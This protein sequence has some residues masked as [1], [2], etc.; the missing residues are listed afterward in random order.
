MR[1][2]RRR[3]HLLPLKP[4]HL[5]V[6]LVLTGSFVVAMA[7]LAIL[8][9]YR[10]TGNVALF[11]AALRQPPPAGAHA[12]PVAASANA[13]ANSGPE[14]FAGPYPSLEIAAANR[15][16]APVR[17]IV[18]SIGVDAAI[19]GLGLDQGTGQMEVPNDV[20]EVGWYSHGPGPGEV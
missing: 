11:E 15:A 8:A 20:R 14:P 2:R 12:T 6:A 10:P 17:L 19:T 5:A 9:D 7:L 18:E 1:R 16:P 4:A 3:R 13:I